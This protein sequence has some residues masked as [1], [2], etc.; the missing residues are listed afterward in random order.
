MDLQLKWFG[1]SREHSIKRRFKQYEVM[2]YVI[3]RWKKAELKRLCRC[4]GPDINFRDLCDGKIL[5]CNFTWCRNVP[6]WFVR[7]LQV[8]FEKEY[9]MCVHL[10]RNSFKKD[11]HESLLK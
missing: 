2:K 10:K 11:G 6:I 7:I 8:Y 9:K 5:G 4:V 1:E 3:I